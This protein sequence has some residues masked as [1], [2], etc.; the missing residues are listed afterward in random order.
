[1]IM[2]KFSPLETSASALRLGGGDDG[3]TSWGDVLSGGRDGVTSLGDELSRK[4]LPLITESKCR[5]EGVT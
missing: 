5:D 1:M 2:K 4:A 3:V